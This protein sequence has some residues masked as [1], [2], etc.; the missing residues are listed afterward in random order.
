VPLSFL[1]QPAEVMEYGDVCFWH[2]A[3]IPAAVN[4][5]RFWE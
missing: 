2:K 3:D 5:V 1:A 4:N